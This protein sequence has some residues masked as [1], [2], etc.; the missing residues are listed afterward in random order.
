[1]WRAPCGKSKNPARKAAQA[2]ILLK[3]DE[4]W[5]APMVADTF[6]PRHPR[7]VCVWFTGLSGAGKSTTAEVLTVLL[8]EHGRQVTVLDR[9]VVR[10]HLSKGLGFSREDRDTNIAG[11]VLWPRR[12]CGTGE[13]RSVPP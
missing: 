10:T 7:G 13:W 11:L 12:S 8:M 1:M 9:D 5:S 6:P 4:G 2:Q 3:G